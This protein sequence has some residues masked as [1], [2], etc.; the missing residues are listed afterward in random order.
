M[1]NAFNAALARIPDKDGKRRFFVLLFTCVP[2]IKRRA[3][4]LQKSA[5]KQSPCRHFQPG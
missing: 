2:G 3:R 5:R 4:L 1:N